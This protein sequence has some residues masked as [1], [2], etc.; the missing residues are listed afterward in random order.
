[1]MEFAISGKFGEAREK[2]DLLL[3]D[4]GL[5]G[6]DIVRQMHKNI[7][8]LDISEFGKVR[9]LDKLGEIEFRII[10]GSNSRIQLESML[11]YF[12]LVGKEFQK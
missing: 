9:F 11:A 10:E 3:V 12:S 7:F 4:F 1:M 5:S 8:E 2:L 6:E